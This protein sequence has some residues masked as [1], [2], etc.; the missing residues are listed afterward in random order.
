MQHPGEGVLGDSAAEV[1]NT[2]TA[3]TATNSAAAAA[4]EME[5]APAQS[6]VDAVA[7]R[8]GSGDS[9]SVTD[10]YDLDRLVGASQVSFDENGNLVV[11]AGGADHRGPRAGGGANYGGNGD[12]ADEY[13]DLDDDDDDD[14]DDALLFESPLAQHPL[15]LSAGSRILGSI[16]PASPSSA[17]SGMGG[18]HLRLSGSGGGGGGVVGGG[19][20]GGGGGGGG[21]RHHGDR[22]T[23]GTRRRLQFGGARAR[24]KTARFAIDEHFPLQRRGPSFADVASLALFAAAT[25]AFFA[26]AVIATDVADPPSCRD[27]DWASAVE[28]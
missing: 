3:P 24:S 15:L 5:L 21:G 7:G 10:E 22:G 18:S 19:G 8:G 13:D 27:S 9:A 23:D 2:T 16:L 4:A 6:S 26:C 17:T 28:P 20:R 12:D 14:D 11:V 25:A 1:A